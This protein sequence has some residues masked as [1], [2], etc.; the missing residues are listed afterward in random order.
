MCGER[1]GAY[2]ILGGKPEVRKRLERLRRRLENNLKMYL[3]E[4]GWEKGL[5]RSG[6]G[7][8]QVKGSCECGNKPSPLIK[9]GEFLD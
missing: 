5:D 3:R 2:R 4:V 6:S 9:W 7:Q 1:R 8:G